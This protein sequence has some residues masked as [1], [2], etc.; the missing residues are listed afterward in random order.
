[1]FELPTA[2]LCD[3]YAELY[4]GAVTDVLDDRGLFDQTLDRHI[5]PVV[6]DVVTA[7]IA[8]PVT[9]EPSE[10]FDRASN[11][12]RLI[13]MLSEAPADAVLLYDT[14]GSTASHIGEIG[15]E[16]LEASGCRGAV[17]DG[18]ARDVRYIREHSPEFPLFVRHTTPAYAIARWEIQDWNV[19]ATV[20]GVE[21]SPGDVVVG[22]VDGVVIVPQDIAVDVL[23]EAER[24][25]ESEDE[26]RETVRSGVDIFEAF[27][28]HG[29]FEDVESA[30]HR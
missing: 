16:A 3:R 17:V 21:V 5:D 12:R 22:D 24:I 6:P 15:V 25:E 11:F 8:Y 4:P 9:G 13:T 20:G 7:G 23:R 14:G 30:T 28:R 26:L 18:G 29:M 10:D 2:E 1:M 19:P 27:E